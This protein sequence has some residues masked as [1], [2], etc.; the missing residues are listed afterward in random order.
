VLLNHQLNL[1]FKGGKRDFRHGRFCRAL[2]TKSTYFKDFSSNFGS[3]CD[4]V[5]AY[6]DSIIHQIGVPVFQ[7]ASFGGAPPEEVIKR[8]P[9]PPYCVPKRAIPMIDMLDKKVETVEIITFCQDSIKKIMDITGMA[10][11]EIYDSIKSAR[12]RE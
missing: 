2:K 12:L 8:K 5:V 11:A 10:L 6:R 1:G 9:S 3:W 7:E 4:A